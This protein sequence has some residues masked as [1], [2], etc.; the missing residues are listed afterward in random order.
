MTVQPRGGY[1]GVTFSPDGK[2]L[3]YTRRDDDQNADV[4]LY[5]LTAKTEYDVTPNPFSESRGVFTPDGRKLVFLSDRDG[6]VMHLFDVALDRLR[7]DPDDPLVKERVKKAPRR[8]EGQGRGGGR[9][10]GDQGGD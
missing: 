6:G 8:A 9:R 3:A 5:D 7:E 1:Q 4:Y 10:V 2:W